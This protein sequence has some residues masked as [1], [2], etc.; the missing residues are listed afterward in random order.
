ML[1]HRLRRWFNIKAA[2]VKRIMFA[3]IRHAVLIRI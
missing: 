2:L 3:G 1:A